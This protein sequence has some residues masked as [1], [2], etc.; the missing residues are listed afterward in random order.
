M[1]ANTIEGL[2]VS[3]WGVEG[4]AATAVVT[5]TVIP[6]AGKTFIVGGVTYTFRAAGDTDAAGEISIGINVAAARLNFVAAINGN[7]LNVANPIVS[8]GAFSDGALP[9]TDARLTCRQPGLTTAV[10]GTWTDD[11]TNSATAFGGGS[12][13]QG[14]AVAATSKISIERLE[15]DDADENSYRP[16]FANGMSVRNRGKATAVQHGTRFSFS[17]QPMVWEQVM[18][19]LS[20]SVLGGVPPTVEA[21]PVYRWTFTRVPI[22]NPLPATFTIERR[23]SNGEAGYID[24]RCSYALLEEIGFSYAQNE[25]LRISGKGFARKF[26]AM[27]GGITG[28][29]SLPTAELGVSALSTVYMDDAW[30]AF[31]GSPTLM[32]EQV[33]G[34]SLTFKTGMQP[35]YTAEGRA[36]LD[37]T[38]AQPNA[39]EVQIALGLTLLLDPTIYAAEAA[40]AAAGDIRAVQIKVVGS[41]LRSM[42]INM[43]AQHSKPMLLKI[44]EQDGQDII[45]LQLEEA[46]DETNFFQVI[47]DHPTIATLA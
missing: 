29:L 28:A 36:N 9:D 5:M 8:C 23:Y 35:L 17:D 39:K 32:A 7:A 24:Q 37:F 44:G 21:G 34:W 12:G 4:V 43:L 22:N 14:T 42:K 20:M 47:V 33:L 15:W 30:S 27:G 2:R 10:T 31:A 18:H 6:T 11:A 25:Q 38:K 45:N 40:H 26:E 13:A 19:W 16:Q 3:Q 1:T 41:A 46:T